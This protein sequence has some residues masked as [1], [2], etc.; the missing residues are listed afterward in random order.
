[1]PNKTTLITIASNMTYTIS[2]NASCTVFFDGLNLR[3]AQE[4]F[5]QSSKPEVATATAAWWD[6]T[7]K[8]WSFYA[9]NTWTTA[10]SA[11]P[12]VDVTI[13]NGTI[14]R[15]SYAGYRLLDAQIPLIADMEYPDL[16][17]DAK[18]I[19]EAIN[20]TKDV[21]D[22]AEAIADAALVKA[23]PELNTSTKYVVGAINEVKTG[24]DGLNAEI[25]NISGQLDNIE[26]NSA[27]TSDY[28]TLK[29]TVDSLSEAQSDI[30]II[31]DNNTTDITKLKNSVGTVVLSTTN[32]TCT[33]AITEI[34]NKIG[35]AT[36][37]TQANT[38]GGAINEL[39]AALNPNKLMNGVAP[40]FDNFHTSSG[41]S[42][43]VNHLNVLL[44]VLR[45][46]GVIE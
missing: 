23:V 3:E 21:A 41:I 10:N 15:L 37:T 14:T 46:R 26:A 11:Q 42:E 40:S 4:V 18:T 2:G 13:S 31:A 16:L 19:I 34:N 17:T 38:L 24:V 20:E 44:T 7:T 25:V 5:W 9:N 1:M 6:P 12:L 36:L 32:K 27:T 8:I 29:S 39:A 35:T 22:V 30:A 33:G 28:L 45:S 43:L